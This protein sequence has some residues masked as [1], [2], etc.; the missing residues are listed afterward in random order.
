MAQLLTIARP[1]AKAVFEQALQSEQLA[2]W[3][4][5][6]RAMAIIS[7]DDR[8]QRLI[9]NPELSKDVLEK[10]Y[11]G[12]I[13]DVLKSIPESVQKQ[14]EN[15][16]KILV[17]EKRLAAVADITTLFLRMLAEHENTLRVRVTSASPLTDEQKADIEKALAARFNLKM[18]VHYREDPELIG[19]AVIHSGNWVMDGS[20]KTKLARL[21]RT[22]TEV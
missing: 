10:F 17:A 21:R 15:L 16:L 2:Q 3:Q 7:R 8:V 1:Y 4:L 22:L 9:H 5:I 6:L 14:L 19:G 13:T 20:V 12:I 11:L 18:S